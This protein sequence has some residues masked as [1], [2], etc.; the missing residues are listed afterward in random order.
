MLTTA[1][2]QVSGQT[3]KE[4]AKARTSA[5]LERKKAERQAA[6]ERDLAA[7]QQLQLQHPELSIGAAL[8]IHQGQYTFEQWLAGR[9]KK[10]QKSTARRERFAHVVMEYERGWLNRRAF[11][12]DPVVLQL[13]GG[14]PARVSRLGYPDRYA[15]SV[16]NDDGTVR[17]LDK[18]DVA[19]V[20]REEDAAC[21]VKPDKKFPELAGAKIAV[22]R[23]RQERKPFPQDVLSDC[24]GKPVVVVLLNGLQLE[25]QVE[26]DQTYTFLLSADGAE[27]LVFKHG[28][29]SLSAC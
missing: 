18:L 6:Y 17:K 12:G 2:S 4:K 15:L 28:V 5:K 3:K 8:H 11:H 27:A 23:S 16:R 25:G 29:W 14:Q 13:L 26:W 24:I 22:S 20:F 19:A 10:A 9:A 21:W 7:A 1:P